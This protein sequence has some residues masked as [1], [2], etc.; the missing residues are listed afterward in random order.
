M[1]IRRYDDSNDVPNR[2]EIGHW[3]PD[4]TW[5]AILQY[6]VIGGDVQTAITRAIKDF[7][8]LNGGN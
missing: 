1:V 5:N 7:R 8:M 2:Y 4:G 3:M 6:L